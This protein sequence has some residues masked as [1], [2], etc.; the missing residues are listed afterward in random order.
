LNLLQ[1]VVGVRL[2]GDV[3]VAECKDLTQ[4]FLPLAL[5][6]GFAVRPPRPTAAGR[7]GF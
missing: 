1:E 4:H 2:E 5:V 6:Q 7:T 3:V